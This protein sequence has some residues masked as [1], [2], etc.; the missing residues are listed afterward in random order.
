MRHALDAILEDRDGRAVLRFERI[1]QRDPDAVWQALTTDHELAHWHPSPFTLEPRVGGAV[2]YAAPDGAAMGDGTVTDHDPP[3]TLGY[4][5]GDDHLLWQLEAHDVGTLLVLTHTFDDRFKAARDA[6]GWDLCLDRLEGLDGADWQELNRSY[7]DRFGIAPEEATPPP[8]GV[9]VSAV[10]PLLMF[11]GN[12]EAAM[13]SY[14]MAFEDA[15]IEKLVRYAGAED[16]PTGK[17]KEGRLRLAGQRLLFLDSPVAHAFTFTPSVSLTVT[18]DSVDAVD[19]LF[20]R[21]SSGGS[22]LMEVGAYPFSERFGWCT[23]RFGV[24]WQIRV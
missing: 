20:A 3:R 15:R 13:R 7:E 22:T 2:H 9:A 10:T 12:A 18:C 6:A 16:G 5:W 8:V 11:E 19:A 23:D 1:L 17:V 21:L 4:T 24:S 14:V